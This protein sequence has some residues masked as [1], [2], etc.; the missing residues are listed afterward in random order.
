MVF[1]ASRRQFLFAL[2]DRARGAHFFRGRLTGVAVH[3]RILRNLAG[4]VGAV[5]RGHPHGRAAYSLLDDGY[6]ARNSAGS[7]SIAR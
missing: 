6:A 1:G 2:T 7:I 4:E 5:G 3:V